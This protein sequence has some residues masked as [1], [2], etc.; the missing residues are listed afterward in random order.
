MDQ[1]R[2]HI[3]VNPISGRYGSR[4]FVRDLARRVEVAGWQVRVTRTRGAGDAAAAAADSCRRGDQALLVVGGDGTINDAASGM[5]GQGVPILAA[6]MGT[7]NVLAKYLGIRRD[8]AVLCGL[9]GRG[10]EQAFDLP[11]MN[12]RQFLMLA[13]VGFDAEVVRRLSQSR[14]GHITYASYFWPTWRTLWSYHQPQLLIETDGEEL[15][16]GRGL[17]FV[18]NIPRYALGL[19]L[20]PQADPTDG[21]LDVCVFECGWQAP[22]VRHSLNVLARRHLSTRGVR[23]A[24]AR[25]I[26]ISSPQRVPVELDGDF[27]GYLPAHFKMT[28]ARARMIV[29]RGP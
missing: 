4:R 18:G 5:V 21:L 11:R 13:G 3:V 28:D 7:E 12:D 16:R 20:L 15:F 2:V 1:K 23:H 6:P 22:L 27:A 17:A 19:R 14:R 29:G 24:R 9:L 8:A 25:S 26:R 10:R